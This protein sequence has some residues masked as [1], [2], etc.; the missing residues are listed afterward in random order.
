[1]S[2]E[3]VSA[4]LQTG[5]V[6]TMQRL[7]KL[8]LMPADQ[9][10]LSARDIR[11]GHIVVTPHAYPYDVMTVDDLV[12]LN[13]GGEKVDGHR[14]P[15]YDAQLHVAVYAARPKVNAVLHTEPPYVNACGALNRH[16]APITTTGL[17]SANGMVPIMP[18]RYK[19]GGE[20]VK[21]MLEVMGDS[22]GVVWQNHGLLVVGETVTQ[23][24]DR[25]VGIEFN[26]QV[27]LLALGAGQPQTLQH[28]GA[29]MVV[30]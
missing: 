8:S 12:V 11:T 19:R 23:V 21:E 4:E 24:A 2:E 6:E 10:N 18:F 17:K 30:A 3:K 26:A 29:E 5:V 28:V 27:L 20:F 13:A 22:H 16:I 7:S 14:E 9:G 1:M 25:S 15:S